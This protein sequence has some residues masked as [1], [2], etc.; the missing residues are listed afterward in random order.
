MLTPRYNDTAQSNHR[1]IADRIT[2][3]GECLLSDL[4]CGRDV[5]RVVDIAIVDL[6]SGNKR[7]DR[8]G[9]GTF[10]PNLVD[11]IVRDLEVLAL[12]NL[13][14][15]TDVLLF[16]RLAGFGVD[17]LLLQPISGLFVDPVER[18]SLRARCGRI[19]RDRTRNQ[20]QLEIPLPGGTRGH[21]D[22]PDT[23]RYFRT[24]SA[25]AR[26]I[27]IITNSCG[28]AENSLNSENGPGTWAKCR[29]ASKPGQTQGDR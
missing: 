12:A 14:A 27:A 9:V 21:R 8:D 28:Y 5:I 20:G 23:N 18:N 4:V 24:G 19:K 26:T 25:P 11:F 3:D 13:V 6:S 29:R 2:D 22:A 16:D 10:D 17:E 1:L 7:I 15:A